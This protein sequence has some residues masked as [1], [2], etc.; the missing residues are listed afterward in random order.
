MKPCRL[1]NR[2]SCRS[3]GMDPLPSISG[4]APPPIHVSIIMDGN[5]R[6][7][8]ARGLPRTT[9]HREG[10]EAVRRTVR[11]AAERGIAYLTLFSFSSE[12][13]KRPE[14]EVGEPMGQIG[15]A[16]WRA[17]EWQYGYIP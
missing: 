17:R 10:A 4:E 8:K 15:K 11:A 13:W 2:K 6:W 3:K 1:R 7:A 9:G 5:G 14:D 16:S 12:N